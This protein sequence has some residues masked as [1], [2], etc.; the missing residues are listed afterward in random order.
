MKKYSIILLTIKFSFNA[1]AVFNSLFVKESNLSFIE[2]RIKRINTTT[3][4]CEGAF[5]DETVF[6]AIY[7]P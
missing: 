6:V 4:R 3:A 7:A 5:N 1:D 2:R